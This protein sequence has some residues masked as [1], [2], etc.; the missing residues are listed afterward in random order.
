MPSGPNK[1][2]NAKLARTAA[3]AAGLVSIG[4][5]ALMALSHPAA[6]LAQVPWP[7]PPPAPVGIF[8]QVIPSSRIT[9]VA[10]PPTP[11]SIAVKIDPIF[12][13]PVPR[14][15][16]RPSA[17]IATS[18]PVPERR[19]TLYL[20]AGVLDRTLQLT[21]EPLKVTQVP[22]TELGRHIQ[23]A[24]QLSTYDQNASPVSPTFR[25][26]LRLQ[27]VV[28]DLELASAG[29][30]PARLYLAQFNPQNN[31]WIPLV[32]TYRPA[33]A[34]I[35]ARILQPGLFALIAQPAP[36]PR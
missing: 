22:Q 33:N 12:A 7:T 23:R 35:L 4:L 6:I 8:P 11:G 14:V 21:Y 5:L 17:I 25:Y 19:I 20:D 9:P 1:I 26:P 28:A 18:E 29:D 13:G 3:L 10:A 31:R 16:P 30:D 24:F 27:L 2:F 36:V 15:P 32:T 34:T